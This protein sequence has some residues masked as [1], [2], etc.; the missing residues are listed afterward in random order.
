M[1]NKGKT[2]ITKKNLIVPT[3]EFGYKQPKLRQFK[4]IKG[5]VL[6]GFLMDRFDYT[7]K[8]AIKMEKRLPGGLK[9]QVIS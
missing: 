5:D 6:I 4:Y 7:A 1:K 2:M 3:K 8:E 9:V